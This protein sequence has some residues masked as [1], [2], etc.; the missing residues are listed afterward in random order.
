M[1][2][3]LT[4]AF[5]VFGIMACGF[6]AR[7]WNL[8][9]PSGVRSLNNFV[10]LFALPALLLIRVA[11]A[12]IDQ[13]FDWRLVT[14]Y[15][16][17]VVIIFSATVLLA[18]FQEGV[19]LATASL[20]G[21][22]TVWSNSGHLGIPLTIT[23]FGADA[24]LPT[25]LVL[26]FDNLVVAPT[27]FALIEGDPERRGAQQAVV[28]TVASRLSRNPVIIAVV[29]GIALAIAHVRLPPPLLTFGELLG[30]GA[31]PCALFALGASLVGVPVAASGT[32][33]TLLSLLKLVAH[34]LLVWL[35]VT[36]VYPADPRASAVLVMVA[37]LPTGTSVFVFAQRYE[38][39]V[40]QTS[41]VILAS[42]LGAVLTVST[43]LV[44][45]GAG[46]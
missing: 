31:A 26:T 6:L 1:Q 44:L 5:P 41:S 22:C 11:E 40:A 7:Y 33:L 25:V 35:M 16:S 17:T 30:A 3:L 20:Q 43:V 2:A 42:H 13:L 14:A 21:L 19:P 18:R 28:R 39:Y 8:L 15:Y 27:V 36:F 32:Q 46:G 45:L 23:A 29:L 9:E 37:A 24:L 34:P 12:P 38:T 10:F 4:V